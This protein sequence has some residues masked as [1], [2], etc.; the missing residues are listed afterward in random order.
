MKQPQKQYYIATR[1]NY[2]ASTWVAN[3]S[4]K[5]HL[6]RDDLYTDYWTGDYCTAR[7]K[8]DELNNNYTLS[9][10]EYGQPDHKIVGMFSQLA[11][12]L[13]D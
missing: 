9:H 10:G 2:Y 4:D 13:L 11:E 6:L 12:K 8:V 7:K 1:R 3:N 5:W